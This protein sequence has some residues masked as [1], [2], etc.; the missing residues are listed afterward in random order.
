[1]TYYT[2]IFKW[3]RGRVCSVRWLHL[4]LAPYK[5]QPWQQQHYQGS[6]NAR[7]TLI[8]KKMLTS[9]RSSTRPPPG[10]RIN[11]CKNPETDFFFFLWL[12]TATPWLRFA[13]PSLLSYTVWSEVESGTIGPGV[14]W[15]TFFRPLC[16]PN[17]CFKPQVPL[18][19]I[20]VSWFQRNRWLRQT[21]L[22]KSHSSLTVLPWKPS[23]RIPT[24]G[25]LCTPSLPVTN[26]F[27]RC[28][29]YSWWIIPSDKGLSLTGFSPFM[30]FLSSA[31][32]TCGQSYSKGLKNPNHST[33][34]L[35]T[36]QLVS[37]IDTEISRWIDR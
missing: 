7:G 29:L 20:W 12:F 6:Q 25:A 31:V 22:L 28:Q 11:V 13:N 8:S 30:L 4:F 36:E 33:Q 2:R 3:L 34:D 17:F 15:P 1:M 21:A 14:C 9:P 32:C 24:W 35:W 5:Q 10:L 26:L 16:H 23:F 37:F 19:M 18:K 27:S